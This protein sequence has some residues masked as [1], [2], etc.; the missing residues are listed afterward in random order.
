MSDHYDEEKLG[1]PLKWIEQMKLGKYQHLPIE[2]L[3]FA[4]DNSSYYGHRYGQHFSKRLS[5]SYEAAKTWTVVSDSEDEDY[6]PEGP[7]EV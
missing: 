5:E 7:P 2:S 1:E 3:R 6:E 4:M